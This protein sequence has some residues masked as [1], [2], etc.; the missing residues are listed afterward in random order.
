M[1]AKGWQK[2][3]SATKARKKQQH[4]SLAHISGPR[5]SLP[6]TKGFHEN[7]TLPT[8]GGRNGEWFGASRPAPTC[9]GTSHNDHVPQQL[10]MVF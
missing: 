1:L 7:C 5:S 6:S 3:I 8:G 4:V 9:D 2:I 10:V